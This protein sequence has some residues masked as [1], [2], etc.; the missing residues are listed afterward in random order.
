MARP[1]NPRPEP[2]RPNPPTRPNNPRPIGTPPTNPR[3][4]G[5]VC[6]VCSGPFGA[7]PC[8]GQGKPKTATAPSPIPP[9]NPAPTGPRPRPPGPGPTGPNRAALVTIPSWHGTTR[10]VYEPA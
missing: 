4:A 10:R 9:P 3:L 7:C 5:P 8:N 2:T 1:P 6:P